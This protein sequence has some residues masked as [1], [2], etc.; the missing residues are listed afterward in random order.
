MIHLQE[1]C[2]ME[3]NAHQSQVY[4]LNPTQFP[5][6]SLAGTGEVGVAG[7]CPLFSISLSDIMDYGSLTWYEQ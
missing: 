1:G 3:P 2:G 5:D 6:L 7:T 4:S